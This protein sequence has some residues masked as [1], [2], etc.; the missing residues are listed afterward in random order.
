AYLCHLWVG[1]R[2][3]DHGYVLGLA[4]LTAGYRSGRRHFAEHG[5]H[6]VFIYQLLDDGL[7]LFLFAAIILDDHFYLFAEQATCFISFFQ[8]QLYSFSG[9]YA[10]G[11]GITG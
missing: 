6:F 11:G 1:R 2:G 5:Y 8:R 4:D 10:K 3:R 9:R 7:G